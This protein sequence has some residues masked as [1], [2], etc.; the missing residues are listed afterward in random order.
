MLQARMV[1]LFRASAAN[2]VRNLSSYLTVSGHPN[3]TRE[4]LRVSLA[5][6][7]A[8]FVCS[9]AHTPTDKAKCLR[10]GR[11]QSVPAAPSEEKERGFSR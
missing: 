6:C 7:A 10:S 2:S 3:L 5:R 1:L 4:I 8:I 11:R 9:I